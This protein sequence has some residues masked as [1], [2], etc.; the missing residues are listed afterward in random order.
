MCLPVTGRFHHRRKN[1]KCSDGEAME[2]VHFIDGRQLQLRLGHTF[3]HLFLFMYE[4]SVCMYAG[5]FLVCLVPMEAKGGAL[6]S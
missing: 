4:C 5:V 6:E 2:D 3:F 1:G